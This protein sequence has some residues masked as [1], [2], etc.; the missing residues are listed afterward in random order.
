M[1]QHY[2]SIGDDDWGVVLCY[3]IDRDDFKEIGHLLSEL[4]ASPKNVD[5][6]L[7]VLGTLNSGLTY[8]SF[9]KRMSLVCIGSATSAEE[10][11]N[12]VLH[13]VK[14]LVEH[15]SDYYGVPPKHED[16]A[17]LQGEVGG[18]LYDGAPMLVCPECGR[19]L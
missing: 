18:R 14:H 15:I 3:D 6:S 5:K 11:F 4:G 9:D 19:E 1:T 10:R 8:T 13:E 2:F 7:R 17:Y 16:A 12:S